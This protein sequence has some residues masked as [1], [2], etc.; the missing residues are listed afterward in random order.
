MRRRS[1][2]F[3]V[4]EQQRVELAQQRLDRADEADRLLRQ[5]FSQAFGELGDGGG[6]ALV[7]V[8]GYGRRELSPHSDLDVVL[9][10]DPKRFKKA[11]KIGPLAEAI[12]YPLWDRKIDLD[13][14]VRDTKQMLEAAESDYRAA[15]GM[16]DTRCVAGDG[17]LVASL[18]STVLEQWRRQARTRITEVRQARDK[19][20]ERSG[21]LAHAAVP[22]LKESGG[23]LRDS[24]TLRALVATWLVD[25][26]HA[27]AESLRTQLLDVRDVMHQ[28]SGRRSDRMTPE[29]VIDVAAALSMTPVELDLHTRDLGRRT[30]HLMRRSLR[31]L[32]LVLA[33]DGRRPSRSGPR[34][35]EVEPGVGVL[36]SEV[37]LLAGADPALDPELVL[38]AAAVAARERLPLNEAA[39]TR[40]AERG[41]PIPEPWAPTANR[42]LNEL[43]SSGP[44]VVDVWEQLDFAGIVD[45]ILP[46]WSGVRLRGSSSPVHRYTVDRHSLEAVVVADQLNRDVARPD[47][48]ALAALIHDI[49]KGRAGDHSA[50]GEPMA[51]AIAQR[52]GF[53]ESDA[54]VVG[55]L[56][57]HHLLLPTIA[58]GRDIEDPLTAANVAEL[59][60]STEFLDLLAALTACDAMATSDTAWSPWRRGLIEGLVDKVRERLASSEDVDAADYA[61][62]PGHVPFPQPGDLAGA[63][64][65]RVE[66][67]PHLDGSLVTIVT[68]DRTGVLA[69][70]AGA[71]TLAGLGI[72]SARLASGDGLVATM[73]EV[74]RAGV[75]PEVVRQRVR[76][77]FSGQI[78]L[79]GKLQYVL[80]PDEM[81]PRVRVLDAMEQTATLLEVRT[82]DRRALMWTVCSTIAGAGWSIRTAHSSTYGDEA[83][84]VFYVVD[85]GGLALL[86]ADAD[87][88]RD[89]VAAA[90][91]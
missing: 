84:D 48:L 23:G 18:R 65:F 30:A 52:W 21:W 24:V 63:D 12:W 7:A 61:G 71:L 22:D 5:L 69:E 54:V 56:V 32:D 27:E 47:L 91:R 50:V 78:D 79:A 90:L 46:E 59:V 82:L 42:I 14:A 73:W 60:G 17:E 58:T 35:D 83:R 26:P 40:L 81:Q 86:D 76:Q 25:V 3:S 87:A 10:Y 43:L 57:L 51:V 6:V 16:L 74:S 85:G 38:R 11:K 62:W 19:R 45:A 64:G 89:R 55:R 72:R 49:G 1:N 20:I 75:D 44:G 41:S 39:L 66:V 4:T 29:V 70:L 9:M 68:N 34:I 88:L 13:H 28:V 31:S 8:G 67:E 36:D 53:T 37:V 33:K 77:V 15:M 2:L 80:K